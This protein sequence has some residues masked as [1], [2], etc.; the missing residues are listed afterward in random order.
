M[1]FRRQFHSGVVVDYLR[2]LQQGEPD[3]ALQAA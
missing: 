1:N 2:K 3:K